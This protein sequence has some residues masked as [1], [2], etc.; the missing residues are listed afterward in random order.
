MC[1]GTIVVYHLQKNSGNSGWFVNGTRFFG[2]FHWKIS[3]KKGISKSL[4]RFPVGTFRWKLCVPVIDLSTFLPVPSLSRSFSQ[5]EASL[6]FCYVSQ[7][8]VC[9]FFRRQCS[10]FARVLSLPFSGF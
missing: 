5:P 10:E 9:V 8:N 4:F 7:N 6:F 1:L 3:E 2:P